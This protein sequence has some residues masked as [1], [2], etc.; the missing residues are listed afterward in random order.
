MID[1]NEDQVRA[2]NERAAER[3]ARRA[4]RQEQAG[5]PVAG[6]LAALPSAPRPAPAAPSA[7]AELAVPAEAPLSGS[8]PADGAFG[9]S[10]ILIAALVVV[11]LFCVWVAERRSR[12]EGD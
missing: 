1:A 9:L 5:R 10:Q 12:R 6:T 2:A 4:A 7:V 3:A 8:A 11:V